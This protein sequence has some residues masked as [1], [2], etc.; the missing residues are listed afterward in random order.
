M[1]G[2]GERGLDFITVILP[3]V[4]GPGSLGSDPTL[5]LP[6]CGTAA[7]F[8]SLCVSTFSSKQG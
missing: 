4:P 8:S 7:R 5:P 1:I 3:Q 6:S 2:W